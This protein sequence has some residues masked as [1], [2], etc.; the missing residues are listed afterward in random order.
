MP[1]YYAPTGRRL[2]MGYKTEFYLFP[3]LLKPWIWYSLKIRIIYTAYGQSSDV[4]GIVRGMQQSINEK[5][6]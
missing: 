1:L 6:K 3:T 4:H 5:R 2:Y